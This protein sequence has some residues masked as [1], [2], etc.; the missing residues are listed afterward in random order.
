LHSGFHEVLDGGAFVPH[1]LFSFGAPITRI[2]ATPLELT[3]EGVIVV[4]FAAMHYVGSWHIA[5]VSIC[6]VMSAADGS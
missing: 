4:R 1:P 2:P 6:G 5:A 3:H